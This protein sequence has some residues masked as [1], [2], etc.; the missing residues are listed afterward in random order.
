MEFQKF[1]IGAWFNWMFVSAYTIVLLL[2]SKQTYDPIWVALAYITSL[3]RS[4]HHLFFPL[5]QTEGAFFTGPPLPTL[6]ALRNV[7][8]LLKPPGAHLSNS[9]LDKQSWP[10]RTHHNTSGIAPCTTHCFNCNLN[11]IIF[12]LSRD[13][14]FFWVLYIKKSNLNLFSF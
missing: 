13:S 14:F 6:T 4:S 9:R 2:Q 8:W 3:F 5:W 1:L 10:Y 7:T 12:L 11:F